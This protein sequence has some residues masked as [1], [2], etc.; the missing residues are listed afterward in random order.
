[1]VVMIG[2]IVN[3][4]NRASQAA[5]QQAFDDA[6]ARA[7]IDS[8]MDDLNQLVCSPK[9]PINRTSSKISGYIA[10]DHFSGDDVSFHSAL[11]PLEDDE[12][13][14]RVSRY[15]VEDRDGDQVYEL[16]K[17]SVDTG[18]GTYPVL[19]HVV[20]FYI[21][22]FDRQGREITANPITQ[23]PEH[24]DIYLMFIS[25]D[26]HKRAKQMKAANANDA[27]IREYLY[28]NGRRHY[29]RA[30]SNVVNGRGV[31]RIGGR[32]QNLDYE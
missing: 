26:V 9:Y 3:D 25:D 18:A 31:R 32:D 4:S 10:A 14:Y 15:C 16:C 11:G 29:M 22:F 24:A 1:M 21:A 5:Y 30:F 27:Y 19:S 23:M 13:T 20:Q 28:K 6:N 7:V 8:L 17:N 12:K 2:K